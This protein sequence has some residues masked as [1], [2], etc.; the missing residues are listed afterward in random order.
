[1]YELKQPL[2]DLQR[3]IVTAMKSVDLEGKSRQLA[4]LEQETMQPDFWNDPNRAKKVSQ[5][6][7]HLRDFVH[8][9]KSV[10]EDVAMLV[11]LFPTI[12][13]SKNPESM[14]EFQELFDDLEKRWKALE[15]QTFL[16]GKYDKNNVILSIHAG[17]GGK[18]AMDFAEMLLRMYVRYAERKKFPTEILDQSFGEEVGV[19]SVTLAINGLFAYGSLKGENGVHRLVRQSPFNSGHSRETS[20][21]L[22]E[23][24]PE[25]PDQEDLEIK[26]EDLRIDLY[27][28]SGAGGQNVNKTESAVRITHLATGLVVAC[29]NERSQLQNK[30]HAMKILKSRLA[31]LME[32]QQ[33]AT[34]HELKGGKI[35]VSWGNQ[36]RSYVL[37][38]YKLVK[39]H[40]TDYEEKVPDKVLDGEIDGFIESYLKRM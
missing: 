26:P 5:E 12:D 9:W 34:L 19:K 30:E 32:K 22:V 2:E 36:I 28:A 35:E 23:I 40:R 31:D 27:H 15:I 21:A 3:Q 6:A 14:K 18:D 39:D 37:H 16:N 17:T 11:E 4:K 25:L 29:Q 33:A 20:F 38:P 8:S 24:L 10:S 7:S 13:V 1:M